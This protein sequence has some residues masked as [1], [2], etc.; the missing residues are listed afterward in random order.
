M[1]PSGIIIP[2]SQGIYSALLTRKNVIYCHID[3]KE[4]TA[5]AITTKVCQKDW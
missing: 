3:G 5:H 2:N 4:A 1:H